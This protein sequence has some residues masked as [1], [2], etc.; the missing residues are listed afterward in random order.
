MAVQ[1]YSPSELH[2]G[3]VLV[4]TGN[5]YEHRDEIRRRAANG[6]RTPSAG[7][8]S[9]GVHNAREVQSPC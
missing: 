5:T 7:G 2:G 4:I 8:L 3:G 1:H 6:T 9:S